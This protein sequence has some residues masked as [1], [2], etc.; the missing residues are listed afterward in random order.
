[1][2]A[3]E[4]KWETVPMKNKANKPENL[5]S[6]K[7]QT[8]TF[9]ENMP[10]VESNPPLKTS[11]TAYDAFI[12]KQKI[13][14]KNSSNNFSNDHFENKKNKEKKEKPKTL[15][16]AT[17]KL[18]EVDV[19]NMVEK[20]Q[21][22][23]KSTNPEA[24]IKELTVVFNSYFKQLP[25]PDVL[26]KDKPKNYPASALK[27]DC[28]NRLLTTLKQAS[29]PTLE[30]IYFLTTQNMVNESNKGAI[31]G[32]QIILQLLSKDNPNII[33]P[34]LNQYLEIVNANKL[35][36]KQSELALWSL[37][38]CCSRDIKVGVKAIVVDY[39]PAMRNKLVAPYALNYIEDFF[40][41]F[42]SLSEAYGEISI[43][44]YF[45]ALDLLLHSKTII[46]PDLRERL[47]LQLEKVKLVAYGS[48]PKTNLRNF[49]PHYLSR[50]DNSSPA[51]QQN[52]YLSS[53][54]QC[55][56][57]DKQCFPDWCQ[58][59]TK[60]LTQSG[61]LLK[62]MQD[63]YSTVVK[64]L[65]RKVL[66]QTIRSFCLTNEEL[67]QAK[68]KNRKEGV[69]KCT[70]V[71]KEL[72]LKLS[73]SGYPWKLIL[74]LLLTIG[75][76]LIAYDVSTSQNLQSSRT[77]VTLEKYGVINVANKGWKNVQNFHKETQNWL[78]VNAPM[79]RDKVVPYM[80]LAWNKTVQLF[81]YIGDVTKPYIKLAWA[82]VLQAVNWFNKEY[83]DFWPKCV[84][85]LNI[86]WQFIEHHSICTWNCMVNYTLISYNW[87][88][89]NVLIGQFSPENI[90]KT[91][92]D[93]L[94]VLQQ[95]LTQAVAWCQK[96]ITSYTS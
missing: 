74:L 23:V 31:Y 48:D 86:T 49:F 76:G 41:R 14:E 78:N 83:P 27:S 72:Q 87:L 47:N 81:I 19:K 88:L 91:A 12:E 24:W 4:G 53:L 66:R 44:E 92:Y 36:E 82:K 62:Y 70:V 43:K 77:M 6:K 40:R 28:S 75:G 8:K 7:N 11:K 16:E 60:Y 1:M 51:A 65:P 67:S 69:D 37:S 89:N 96:T 46:E 3:S 84:E 93:G 34:R 80:T 35:K 52:E 2:M 25:Q 45:T 94:Q 15:E 90:Q 50:L 57:T 20:A 32:Y 56:S 59:Y 21:G 54:I 26:H 55:L 29:I 73:Q 61:C 10:R 17:K 95:Y 79:Y 71:C 68:P 9:I 5:K 38:Q 18:E 63:H 22:S 64:K 33:V 30:Q 42:T 39:I 85:Y 13:T 58:L